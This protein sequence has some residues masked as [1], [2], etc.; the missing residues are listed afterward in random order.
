VYLPLASFPTVTHAVMCVRSVDHALPPTSRVIQC[1]RKANLDAV[2]NHWRRVFDFSKDDIALPV[3]HWRIG[4]VYAALWGDRQSGV[5]CTA[6]T[7]WLLLPCACA[8][9]GWRGGREGSSC[10]RPSVPVG[11]PPQAGASV[12]G[13]DPCELS[14]RPRV[15]VY[16]V[17]D[18]SEYSPWVVELPGSPLPCENPVPLDA[19]PKDE[20]TAGDAGGVLAFDIRTTSQADAEKALRGRG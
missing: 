14:M 8:S 16:P 4:G 2:H 10:C 20:A 7:L 13:T 19:A 18:M 12:A 17:T 15:P 5:G 3:P 6:G 1:F 11:L 9:V